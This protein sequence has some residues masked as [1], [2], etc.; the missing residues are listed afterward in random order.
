MGSFAFVD[1]VVTVNAVN[2]SQF[3]RQATIN[4][5][6]DQ[7]D[8]TAM[9]DTFRSRLGGLKDWTIAL[10]FNE[11]YAAGAVDATLWP[12]LGTVVTVTVKATSA[13]T[14]ATNPLYSGPVLV[15]G[16]TPVGG[17]VGDLATVGVTWQG[18]GPLTRATS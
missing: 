18:A 13:A 10:E 16:H 3:V 4:A 7:L 12:L 11:D 1:A 9:G 6:A 8:D 2:L 17:S 5:S 15:S 14:S